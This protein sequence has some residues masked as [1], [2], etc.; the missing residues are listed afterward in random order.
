[1]PIEKRERLLQTTDLPTA[2]LMEPGPSPNL[3]AMMTT[4]DLG[5][6]AGASDRQ[7]V[8]MNGSAAEFSRWRGEIEKRKAAYPKSISLRCSKC[9]FRTA[10]RYTPELAEGK[11]ACLLCNR[12]RD[13]RGGLLKQMTPGE[14]TEWDRDRA[15]GMERA[16]EQRKKMKEARRIAAMV[17][18]GRQDNRR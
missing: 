11:T 14:I 15:A 12:T 3:D 4:G 13:R 18:Y 10:V 7:F 1:M 17:D 5:G 6:K 8:L 2:E 16:T 9:G